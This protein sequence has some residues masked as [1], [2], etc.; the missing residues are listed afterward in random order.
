MKAKAQS[1]KSPLTEESLQYEIKR[2]G[3]IRYLLHLPKDY[4]PRAARLGR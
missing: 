4:A 2:S 3:E 1:T